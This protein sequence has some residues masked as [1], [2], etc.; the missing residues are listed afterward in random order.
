MLLV[1]TKS[2]E[3]QRVY[4]LG[5]THTSGRIIFVTLTYVFLPSSNVSKLLCHLPSFQQLNQ[6]RQQLYHC[7]E[8]GSM[9]RWGGKKASKSKRQT[10]WKEE[11]S[12]E[13]QEKFFKMQVSR[14]HCRYGVQR[15]DADAAGSRTPPTE[16]G[17]IYIA[18][19]LGTCVLQT[20]PGEALQ[21]CEL[22]LCDWESRLIIGPDSCRGCEKYILLCVNVQK[23]AQH[24]LNHPYIISYCYL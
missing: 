22:Q 15:G 18:Q 7:C 2:I 16:K 9:G 5:Y 21:H 11:N 17:S 19:Q 8:P 23:S 3:I 13:N 14:S 12:P 20:L 10:Q 6:V 4:C 24:I 1:R